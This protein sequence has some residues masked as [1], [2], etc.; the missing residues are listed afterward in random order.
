MCFLD[1]IQPQNQIL[2]F[3]DSI[4]RLRHGNKYGPSAKISA[5]DLIPMFSFS[6]IVSRD[7]ENTTI[8]H[9]VTP[10]TLLVDILLSKSFASRKNNFEIWHRSPDANSKKSEDF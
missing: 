6:E 2:V 4:N 8:A 5:R 9:F 3:T 1:K 7:H 10:F